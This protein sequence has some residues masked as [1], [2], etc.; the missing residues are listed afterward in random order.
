MPGIAEQIRGLPA[1]GRGRA[2]AAE[3]ARAIRAHGTRRGGVAAT[4]F[5]RLASAA[6]ATA[7]AEYEIETQYGT[8]TVAVQELITAENNLIAVL[9]VAGPGGAVA[10]SNPLIITNPP[11]MVPD[12]TY[13]TELDENGEENILA[14]MVDDPG[15]AWEIILAD[16]LGPMLAG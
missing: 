1:R 12:G 16:L 15:R 7:V 3:M 6:P 10:F 5:G 9:D 14:N 13:R 8:A 11:L 2:R 4:A